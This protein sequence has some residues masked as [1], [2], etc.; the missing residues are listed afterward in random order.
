M[1]T[2]IKV[3]ELTK[4]FPGADQPALKEISF[5]IESGSFTVILGRS[6]SGK[7]TLFR[8]LNG[9]LQP[10]A[11]HIILGD[12]PFERLRGRQ[13]R[14]VQRQFATI[15]QQFNLVRH[16][17]VVEN[18][19]A[20]QLADMPLWK[21]ALH[22]FSDAQ[23]QIALGSL[24][25]VGLL[26]QAGQRADS[27]SGG[28]QQRVAIARALVQQS[29]VILADEPIASLDPQSATVVMDELQSIA[30]EAGITIL[31]NLH[32]EDFALRYAT[33]IIG[34]RAGRVVV[35]VPVEEFTADHRDRI[36]H[37]TEL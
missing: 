15:F 13:R 32:Q 19:L 7:T 29:R 28:Q 14:H 23:Q 5:E 26:E 4:Q 10:D 12:Q 27:L 18:V 8:C 11:G 33:H 3:T 9:L 24:A 16:L 25:R 17:T 36:Y 22:R 37:S 21:V 2:I 31:C 6:G 30:Q 1:N 35:S 20:G 34:L